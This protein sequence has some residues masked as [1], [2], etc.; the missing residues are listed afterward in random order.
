MARRKLVSTVVDGNAYTSW[1]QVFNA[2]LQDG[3]TLKL[4]DDYTASNDVVWNGSNGEY[5]LDLNGHTMSA[6]SG[7]FKPSDEKVAGMSLTIR[8]T[9]EDQNGSISHII[10]SS[11]NNYRNLTL[12]SGH[13]GNLEVVNY[14]AAG[15]VLKG[16]SIGNLQIKEYGPN[17]FMLEGGSIGAD[18]LPKGV[19]LADRLYGGG[20]G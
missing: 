15:V 19:M 5:I 7:A 14:V 4:Y 8:D 9:S 20:G 12:D 16:G 6:G 13:I 2:W 11:E 10:L 17:G 3:G 18:S 1:D